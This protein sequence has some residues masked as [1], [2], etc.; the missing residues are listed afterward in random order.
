ME[1]STVLTLYV[2]TKSY[3]FSSFGNQLYNVNIKT[4]KKAQENIIN[5]DDIIKRL[6]EAGVTE[7]PNEEENNEESN[8]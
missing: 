1:R 6:A 3:I 7:L 5:I 8:D 4:P 2:V